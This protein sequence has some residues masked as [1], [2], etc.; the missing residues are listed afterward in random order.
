MTKE[1]FIAIARIIKDA[2]SRLDEE[3]TRIGMGLR[4]CDYFEERYPN[5]KPK[6]FMKAA[7]IE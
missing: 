4:L 3:R 1:D 2:R 6:V 5:F 7:D